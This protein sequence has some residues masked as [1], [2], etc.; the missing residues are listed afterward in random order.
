MR[1]L[2]DMDGVLADF[3]QGV[4]DLM[5]EHMPEIER[6]P[7]EAHKE[8]EVQYNYPTEVRGKIRALANRPGFFRNL[9]PIEGA[10][11][12][13]RQLASEGRE[14]FICTAPLKEWQN[15][16]AEK[17]EWV[18]KY[19]GPE[20]VRRIILTRDKTLVDAHVLIDDRPNPAGNGCQQPSWLHWLYDQP[21][22]KEVNAIRVT[23]AS[24]ARDGIFSVV[25]QR[26][27]K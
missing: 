7:Y 2:V 3:T 19:L 25:D 21:Y 8:F 11:Q 20:F 23:W 5:A 16:V 10:I 13:I 17:Y 27:S 15:C 24:I 12:G 9:K 6:L 4:L 26:R 14:V 22:N 18:E 1:F